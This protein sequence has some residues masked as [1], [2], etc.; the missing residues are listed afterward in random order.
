MAEC[1]KVKEDLSTMDEAMIDVDEFDPSKEEHITITRQEF[2]DLSSELLNGI[3]ATVL[4]TIEKNDYQSTE[5]NKVLQVGGGC[6]MPMIKNLLQNMFNNAE[7]LCDNHHD[8]IVAIGAAFYAYDKNKNKTEITVVIDKNLIS[9][10]TIKKFVNPGDVE[11]KTQVSEFSAIKI[12]DE[13]TVKSDIKP[14][15]SNI[16]IK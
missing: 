2:E 15:K 16:T 14:L 4:E 6:R 12:T 3:K 10:E 11:L 5:I 7:H 8:E 9:E 13:K 1:Q